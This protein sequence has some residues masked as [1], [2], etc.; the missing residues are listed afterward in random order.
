M[1]YA[2]KTTEEHADEDVDVIAA[3][4]KRDAV[5]LENGSDNENEYQLCQ[6]HFV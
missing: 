4:R 6:E 5:F 3:V 1:G 2:D